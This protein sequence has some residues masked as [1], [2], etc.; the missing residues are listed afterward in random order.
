[1]IITRT[2]VRISIGGGGT[3]LPSYYERFGGFV[4]AA[5]I[6]QYV[7]VGI[8]RMFGPGYLLKYSN[9]EKCATVDEIQHPILREVLRRHNGEG[10]IE[11]ASLADVPAG[12]GLGSSGAF[13]VGLLRA[14][15][16]HKREHVAPDDIAAEACT[17]E[18]DTLRQAVGKQDQYI[19]AIGG[20][21]CFEFREDGSVRH[22]RLNVSDDTLRDLEANL[23]MYFTGYVHNAADV[24]NDQKR[25]SLDGDPGMIENLHF[26]KQLGLSAREAL[27]QGK[28]RCYAELLN[29]HWLH[30]RA[31]SKGMTN[32]HIDRWYSIARENGAVGGKLVG[33]GGG[34]FLLFYAEDPVR[35]RRALT[36]EGLSEMN[37]RFD[38]DGSR[39][40][41][42]D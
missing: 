29:E 33:A 24:L 10:S 17:I 20:L 41:V 6:S 27:E 35:L 30:K 21:T 12:T 11:I 1:M 15:Y 5:A 23:V 2:P 9:L 13:T 14:L 28:T 7:Y 38:H 34:G 16:A 8:N 42:R 36:A 39:V 31:R 3:D 37:F 40:L 4:I 25:R 32:P 18:I 26:T 22:E 19:A